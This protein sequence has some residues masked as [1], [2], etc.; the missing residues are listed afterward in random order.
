MEEIN[1]KDLFNYYLKR[2]PIILLV[3]VI[4]VGAGIFYIKK[5]QV[6]MYHGTTTILLVQKSGEEDNSSSYQ[7]ELSLNQKLVATYSQI[8][9]SRK[10]LDQVINNLK[11]KN[12]TANSLS[13]SIE[14]SGVTDTS[15]IKITVSN[16]D[17][18]KAVKIAN[19]VSNVF[20]NEVSA[21]YNLENVSVIDEAI[22]ENNP[23]NI[24]TK[25]ELLVCGLIGLLLSSGIIFVIYYFDNTIKSKADI[26]DSLG[27]P[28]LSE[29]PMA[30]KMSKSKKES[31]NEI[32]SDKFNNI[33]KKIT[34]SRKTTTRKRTTTKSKGDK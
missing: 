16:K 31:N 25:K 3:V 28:V 12:V 20:K 15:I 11:L 19:E 4:F 17:N 27:L 5:I 32:S 13:S 23:Y 10:V 9:K 29:V 22:V 24:N 6:P 26:E 18:K 33:D 34:N 14:V 21:I 2:L 7:S 1:L 30:K 8:I